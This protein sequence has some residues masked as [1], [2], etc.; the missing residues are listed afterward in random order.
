MRVHA[1]VYINLYMCVCVY[2]TQEFLSVFLDGG[3]ADGPTPANPPTESDMLLGSLPAIVELPTHTTPPTTQQTPATNPYAQNLPYP[4]P[5]EPTTTTQPGP[6]LTSQGNASQQGQ[7]IANGGENG[8]AVSADSVDQG[9]LFSAWDAME[10]EEDAVLQEAL[11]LLPDLDNVA[12]NMTV[13]GGYDAR[14][15]M[16]RMAGPMALLS[17]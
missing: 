8:L 16:G 6:G 10:E 5:Q 3:G 14:G 12:R 17:M 13:P 1:R 4:P 7:S 11:M 9:G 15:M 2:V